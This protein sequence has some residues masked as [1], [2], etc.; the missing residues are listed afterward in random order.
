M[1]GAMRDVARIIDANANR[2]REAARTME[3]VARFALDDRDLCEELKSIRHGLRE[4]LESL[5]LDCAATLASRDTPGD[6]GTGVSTDGERDRAGLRDVALAAG[7]RLSEA[8]RVME[9]C[10]KTVDAGGA[11]VFEALRYRA[12]EAERA[13]GLAMLGGR[14][15]RWRVC[16]IVTEAMCGG[17]GWLDVARAAI[18]GGADCLQLREKGLESREL[19][20]R[21]RALVSLAR[22][23][24][25][26][27][28][29]I[30]NDRPDVAL[31]AGADGVHVGQRDLSVRDVRSLA[32]GRLL[33]GVSASSVEEARAALR[34]G[35]DYCGVGAMFPTGTKRKDAIAGPGLIRAYAAHEPALPPHV[36]IGGVTPENV[37]VV[38]EAGARGV[39][40]CACVCASAEP[41]RVVAAL[42]EALEGA[43]V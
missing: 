15:P 28:S 36:A 22:G 5:P 33:V 2:A 18:E 43:R 38:V 8:L 11:S 24:P 20:E 26:R 21:A 32:G 40:V 35:A 31:L 4:A 9:E 29:V 6:V 34:E 16:V 27:P 42:R 13:L 3:D 10:A 41:A 12:Y 25:S 39:A 7:K 30:V 23:A 17:R 1:I 19:L 37:R 14:A